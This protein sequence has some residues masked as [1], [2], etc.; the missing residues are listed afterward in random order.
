MM[1]I[2]VCLVT[3]GAVGGAWFGFLWNE[4][5]LRVMHERH[6]KEMDEIFEEVRRLRAQ[7]AN[8]IGRE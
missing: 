1:L 5:T 3:V 6:T 4:N 8:L 7:A 2:G